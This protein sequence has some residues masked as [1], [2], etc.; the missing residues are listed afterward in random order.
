MRMRGAAATGAALSL[1]VALLP[2]L[3]GMA[4]ELFAAHM[5]QHLILITITAPLLALALPPRSIPGGAAW[6]T[7]VAVFLFWHW[8]AA[9]QWAAGS[10]LTQALELGSILLAATLF[11]TTM[12][13]A[14]NQGAAAL[15]VT[16]AAVATDVPGVIMIFA[17]RAICILPHANAAR[18]GLS[19][20]E[21]QQVAGLLMWVPAN[22]V[23]FSIA[24]LLF[25]RWMRAQPSSLVTS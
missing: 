21:D 13:G 10:A 20:L 23:F 6:M 24:T 8:P 5:A 4:Q 12:F 15:L 2:P 3:A 1:A 16:A 14:A 9:F 11:W 22:L 18:F 7:F 17:P 25:A 19:P